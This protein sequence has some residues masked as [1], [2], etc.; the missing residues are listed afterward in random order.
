MAYLPK[1]RPQRSHQIAQAYKDNALDNTN[2]EPDISAEVSIKD[3]FISIRLP[4]EFTVS[5]H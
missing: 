1:L 4:F 2:H 5:P 3:I